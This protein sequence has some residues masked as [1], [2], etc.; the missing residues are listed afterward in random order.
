[1]KARI[2]L[3]ISGL[4][5]FVLGI[6]AFFYFKNGNSKGIMS[7]A[8]EKVGEMI[9]RNDISGREAD[10]KVFATD[11][12]EEF[13][14]NEDVATEKYTGKIIEVTGSIRD[15][16]LHSAK[17]QDNSSTEKIVSAVIY[18]EGGADS[19]SGVICEFEPNANNEILSDTDTPITIKGIFSGYLVD[20]VLHT[21]TIVERNE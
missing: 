7:S 18:L 19:I 1:M 14:I 15:I 2:F 10:F 5:L 9:P 11:L 16:E 6:T 8:I 21:C 17:I 20:V 13:E 3:I 12:A 4:L